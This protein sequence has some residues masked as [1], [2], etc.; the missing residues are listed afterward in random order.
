LGDDVSA[1]IELTDFPHVMNRDMDFK[2]GKRESH[3]DG[4][5][6]SNKGLEN[7][8]SEVSNRSSSDGRDKDYSPD[9]GE[10]ADG[11]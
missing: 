2:M 6:I 1:D 5:N 10:D 4:I 9:S 3:K 7:G 11:A 8:T